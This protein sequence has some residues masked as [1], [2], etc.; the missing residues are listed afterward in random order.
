MPGAIDLLAPKKVALVASNPATSPTTG[1]P[2]GFWWAE[3]THP[4]WEFLE[5]GF[6]VGVYSPD[7]GEL[8][9]DKL[10]DPR[11]ASGYSADDLISLGFINSPDHRRL[12]EQ[13]GLLAPGCIEHRAKV[14]HIRVRGPGDDQVIRDKRISVKVVFLF[15]DLVTPLHLPGGFVDGV[16]GPGTGTDEELIA[17]NCGT[18]LD[19]TPGLKFPK[20]STFWLSDNGDV[21]LLRGCKS[22]CETY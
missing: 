12:V 6:E 8:Q 14:V 16:E 9:G 17:R 22:Q 1:W 10:S 4:Y 7:G 21:R 3:L 11:D 13:R 5:R 15:V 2:V 18:G 19:S 20:L